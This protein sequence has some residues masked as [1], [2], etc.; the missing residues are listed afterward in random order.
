L[1][2]PEKKLA[3]PVA[4]ENVNNRLVPLYQRVLQ[5]PLAYISLAILF[6]GAPW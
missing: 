5:I 3:M 6:N 2:I 1:G 4:Q